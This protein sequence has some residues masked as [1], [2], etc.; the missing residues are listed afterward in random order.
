MDLMIFF[1]L[2]FIYFVI[3]IIWIFTLY[4]KENPLASQWNVANTAGKII[5]IL[6]YIFLSPA[7]ILT[8]I[9]TIIGTIYDKIYDLLFPRTVISAEKLLIPYSSDEL[10]NMSQGLKKKNIKYSIV[11]YDNDRNAFK[12]Y[13]KYDYKLALKII[14]K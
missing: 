9:A 14:K 12:F 13:N 4:L 3:Q 8:G 2:D 5:V 11:R 7:Y 1:T 6:L 10:T